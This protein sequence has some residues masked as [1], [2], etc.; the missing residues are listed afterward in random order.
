MRSSHRIAFQHL[1]CLIC[2]DHALVG[3]PHCSGAGCFCRLEVLAIPTCAMAYHC[4]LMPAPVA[5]GCPLVHS[6]C[7]SVL[8]THNCMCGSGWEGAL[9]L[10]KSHE[11][12]ALAPP[13]IAACHF[14]PPRGSQACVI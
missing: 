1:I 4:K 6:R 14:M 2:E 12:A 7:P 9:A 11:P 8:Q 3:D 13:L 10:H 5:H